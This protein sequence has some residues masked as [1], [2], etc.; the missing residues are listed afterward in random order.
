[1]LQCG[2]CHQTKRD[3]NPGISRLKQKPFKEIRG[4]FKRLYAHTRV[5]G[6][7]G[8]QIDV[9]G[10]GELNH[11][12]GTDAQDPRRWAGSILKDIT[13]W[14]QTAFGLFSSALHLL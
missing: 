7:L 10:E 14:R 2:L 4:V 9:K 11:S 8:M 3:L 13:A 6:V 1:M 5:V 12:L